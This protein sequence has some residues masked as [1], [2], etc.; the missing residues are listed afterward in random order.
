MSG[1]MIMA[2]IKLV[3][4]VMAAKTAVEG[5]KEGNLLKAVAG[6]VG[7][8]MGFNGLAGAGGAGVS[9]TKDTALDVATKS[10]SATAP[11]SGAG[12]IT[13]LSEMGGLDGALNG[14]AGSLSGGVSLNPELVSF[15]DSLGAGMNDISS[16]VLPDSSTY[17]Q[18]NL[19]DMA[20]KIAPVAQPG[21]GLLETLS[22]YGGKAMDY[23]EKNPMVAL[24][25][26]QVGGGLL[27]GMSQEKM[28]EAQWKRDDEERRRR[29]TTANT[30]FL[31]KLTYDPT[32]GRF[33]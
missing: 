15:N 17:L 10:G 14:T 13:A 1:P 26:A 19:G 3:G 31:N 23:M 4:S 12:G 22:E 9:A 27:Q 29:S 30:N 28:Q 8:Y 2:G 7:A 33:V 16:V 18:N 11:A 25:A 32:R 20:S 5:I 21:G 6:G 24:T